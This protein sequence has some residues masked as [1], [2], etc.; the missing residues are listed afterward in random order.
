[1]RNSASVCVGCQSAC[2]FSLEGVSP[3][4]GPYITQRPG[5]RSEDEEEKEEEKS[6]GQTGVEVQRSVIKCCQCKGRAERIQSFLSSQKPFT[7]PT[8]LIL[9]RENETLV[10]TEVVYVP[11]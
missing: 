7:S 3:F 2:V 10:S 4:F 9:Q 6:Q 8:S 1:M 11:D 5:N